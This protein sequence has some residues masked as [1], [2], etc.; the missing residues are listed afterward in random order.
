MFQVI[1]LNLLILIFVISLTILDFRYEGLRR[2]DFMNLMKSV[3]ENMWNE[4]K[5]LIKKNV[6]QQNFLQEWVKLG[7]RRVRGSLLEEKLK[8]TSKKSRCLSK[9]AKFI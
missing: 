8:T 4:E 5:D 9:F 1:D 3:Q 7:G 2:T 6:H